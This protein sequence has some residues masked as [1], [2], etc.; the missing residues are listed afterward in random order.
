MKAQTYVDELSLE[1]KFIKS[2]ANKKAELLNVFMDLLNT[3]QFST[4][5]ELAIAL[6]TQGFSNVSQAKISRLLKKTRA[7]KTFTSGQSIYQLPNGKKQPQPMESVE[8]LVLSMT[9]NN[10]QIVLNPVKGGAELV[11]K[12]IDSMTTSPDI[13]GCIASDTTILIIPSDI[14]HHQFFTKH[15]PF[16]SF[17]N[18]SQYCIWIVLKKY[19]PIFNSY[20]PFPFKFPPEF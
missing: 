8:S 9:H 3:N 16:L 13:L 12:M 11:S 18:F 4:Q 19:F 20:H 6:E 5:Q 1:T 15:I 14:R 10:A 2:I 7:I 17:F